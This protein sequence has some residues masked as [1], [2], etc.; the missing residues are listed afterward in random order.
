MH[1]FDQ[2]GLRIKVNIYNDP[3]RRPWVGSGENM[4]QKFSSIH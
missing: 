3:Q 2:K 1:K 4:R